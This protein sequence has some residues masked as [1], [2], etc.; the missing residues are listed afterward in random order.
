MKVAEKPYIVEFNG[1]PFVLFYGHAPGRSGSQ[2]S[3]FYESNITINTNG[4]RGDNDLGKFNG[5]V[6]LRWSEQYLM[7]RKA[8]LFGDAAQAVKIISAKSPE[9]AKKLGRGVKNF[10]EEVW[11]RER[12]GIMVAGLMEKFKDPELR[13][14][15]L[16]T[17]EATIVECS[18]TDKIWGIGLK[19]GDLR[20]FVKDKWNGLNLLGES[21][22]EVRRRILNGE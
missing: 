2:F 19:L 13:R 22:M 11:V 6:T 4:I 21:L 16:E 17:G 8:L 7:L 20:C 1:Q 10:D 3:N 9:S 15:L 5:E 14:Y 18:P 12:F